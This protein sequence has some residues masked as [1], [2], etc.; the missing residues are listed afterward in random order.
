MNCI[1]TLKSNFIRYY[2]YNINDLNSM[3]EADLKALA[4][5]MGLKKIDSYEKD[6]LVYQIL[7]QQAIV[8]SQNGT[9]D[10]T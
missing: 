2:M 3:S 8:E 5:S 1:L 6:D 9:K 10:D 4:T 7:D